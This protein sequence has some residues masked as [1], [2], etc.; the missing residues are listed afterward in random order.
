MV[1]SQLVDHLDGPGLDCSTVDA[2]HAT[3]AL[4]DREVAAH[5]L[6]RHVEP[7]G[8]GGYGCAAVRAHLIGYCSLS[9]FGVHL[10]TPICGVARA[11]ANHLWV[12]VLWIRL[13]WIWLLRIIVSLVL[14]GIRC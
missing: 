9:L 12:C 11:S 7:V 10:S 13:L 2:L 5:R 6:A 14:C 1:E 3:C 8:E 4:E